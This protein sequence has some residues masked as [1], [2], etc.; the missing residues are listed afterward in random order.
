MKFSSIHIISAILSCLAPQVARAQTGAAQKAVA[1]QLFDDAQA[2]A[3][4]GEMAQACA[5]YAES[6]RLDPQLGTLLYLGDCYDK[7][8]KTASA[9]A[10]FKDAVEIASQRNDEREAAARAKLAELTPKLSRLTI[11]IGSG[12]PPEIQIRRNG[13]LLG[14]TLIGSPLPVDPGEHTIVASAQGYEEWSSTVS[15]PGAGS[16]IVVTVPSL[17]PKAFTLVPKPTPERVSSAIATANQNAAPTAPEVVAKDAGATR[18]M[19]GYVVGSAGIVGL[20]VGAAFGLEKDSKVSER[21]SANACSSS[22]G[23]TTT[24]VARIDQ[25]TSDANTYK[26]AANISFVAGGVALVAGTILAV[27]AWPTSNHP[28]SVVQL[29]PWLGNK[30][31]G[32][33]AGGVW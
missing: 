15:V 28:G 10:S 24:Q 2:L 4:K 5:K 29:Q 7:L 26:T 11:E 20:A 25:L 12:A 3:A 18:R 16:S 31:A 8:G 14:Q 17:T 21:T 33:G 30:S 23:C 13:A 6:E 32:L 22:V 9:W 19:I 27:T 1:A